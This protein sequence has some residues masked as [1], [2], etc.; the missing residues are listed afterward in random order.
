MYVHLKLFIESN[1]KDTHST[2]TVMSS[3]LA[4][5]CRVFFF[6]FMF[7]VKEKQWGMCS[8][9]PTFSLMIPDV[10]EELAKLNL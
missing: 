4:W 5:Y 8:S 2:G 6:S 3:H 1:E 10:K 7:S 9:M